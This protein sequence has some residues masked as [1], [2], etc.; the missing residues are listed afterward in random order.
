MWS[1]GPLVLAG[2]WNLIYTTEKE[3]L[4]LIGDPGA[5]VR[6]EAASSMRA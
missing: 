1:F 5:A 2:T 4:S 6:A 3:V